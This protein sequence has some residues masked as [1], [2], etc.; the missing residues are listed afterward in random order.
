MIDHQDP[1][2]VRIKREVLEGKPSVTAIFGDDPAVTI[3]G[4]EHLISSGKRGS[5]S[6]NTRWSGND[7]LRHQVIT[8]NGVRYMSDT[9]TTLSEGGAILTIAEH[10]REPGLERIRNWVFER[11]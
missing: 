11:Q 3:D 10:Y 6:V 2:T 4:K 7:L 1:S 9:R 5:V 8:I